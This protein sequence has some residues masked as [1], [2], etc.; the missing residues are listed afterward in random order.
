MRPNVAAKLFSVLLSSSLSDRYVGLL[1]LVLPKC[2]ACTVPRS[3]PQSCVDRCPDVPRKCVQKNGGCVSQEDLGSQ[4][5]QFGRLRVP[6]DVSPHV[7]VWV[8]LLWCTHPDGVV[9]T[10]DC[11]Q[12]RDANRDPERAS[13]LTPDI[14]KLHLYEFQRF[15]AEMGSKFRSIGSRT[16]WKNRKPGFHKDYFWA[17][18]AAQQTRA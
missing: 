18:V 12:P 17:A 8:D 2:L 3:R 7:T 15:R 16:L 10:L 6:S 13:V 11:L 9:S 5:S 4:L 14:A 1:A